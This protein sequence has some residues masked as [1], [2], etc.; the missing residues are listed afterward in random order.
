M[1]LPEEFPCSSCARAVAELEPDVVL[2]LS[3]QPADHGSM[4]QAN[5]Q[6]AQLFAF[7]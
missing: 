7:S 6:G 4:V 5:L 1:M 2:I 3:T